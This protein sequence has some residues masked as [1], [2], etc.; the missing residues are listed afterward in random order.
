[1]TALILFVLLLVAVGGWLLVEM[2]YRKK[3]LLLW[4][5]IPVLLL[6]PIIMYYVM[7][8]ER[9]YP[10]PSISRLNEEWTL[11]YSFQ[12]S[13]EKTIYALV[14]HRGEK[15]PRYYKIVFAS[16]Q[17]YEEAAKAFGMAQKKAEKGQIVQGKADSGATTPGV[18]DTDAQFQM[19]ELPPMEIMKKK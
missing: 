17:K 2:T 13:D 11:V 1:M 6:S 10:T 12:N 7:D 15:D 3:W 18:T 19:Y 8:H 14:R 9:G 5:T 16:R 4:L